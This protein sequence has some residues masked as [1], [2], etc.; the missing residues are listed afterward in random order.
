[1]IREF[2]EEEID[3]IKT[4]GLS[5][6]IGAMQGGILPSKETELSVD[7]FVKEYKPQARYC[8]KVFFEDENKWKWIAETWAS[9]DIYI[10]QD[11]RTVTKPED[12]QGILNK[13]LGWE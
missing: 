13:M 12:F 4:L 1:M 11:L 5:T 2:T 6:S 10:L 8:A 9:V 3:T 7:A